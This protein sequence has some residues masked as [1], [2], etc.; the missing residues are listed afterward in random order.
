MLLAAYSP[1]RRAAVSPETLRRGWGTWTTLK[2]QVS[3]VQAG[4]HRSPPSPYTP[5][6]R[7]FLS[8]AV[9]PVKLDT[10]L[11]ALDDAAGDR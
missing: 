3:G 1:E 6:S 11:Q 8:S 7:S 10:L 4:S 9:S 2:R 5:T